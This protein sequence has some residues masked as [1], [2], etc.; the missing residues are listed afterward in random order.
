MYSLPI[1][2]INVIERQTQLAFLLPPEPP[3][4]E[5]MLV[6]GEFKYIKS[7]HS[8]DMLQNAYKAI[9]QTETWDF[10]KKDIDSFMCSTNP[11]IWIITKKM[12][13]LGYDAHSGF[14]FG[15]TMRQ[16]QFIAKNGEKEFKKITRT[17]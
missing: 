16:M 8:R 9:T 6:P 1:E 14:S 11:E 15:W 10:V 4:E 5:D 3:I 2:S 12:V 17:W 13:D 7:S